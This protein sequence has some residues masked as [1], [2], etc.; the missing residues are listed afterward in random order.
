MSGFVKDDKVD[1][2]PKPR[3][4]IHQD[5]GD[6]GDVLRANRPKRRPW[7]THASCEQRPPCDSTREPALLR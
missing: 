3:K 1:I 5:F 7:F 2:A 6:F 4:L